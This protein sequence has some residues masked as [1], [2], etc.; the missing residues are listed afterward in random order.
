MPDTPGALILA[1]MIT[2]RLEPEDKTLD[3]DKMPTALKLL[4]TLGL[5]STDAL[6]IR[7]DELLTPDRRLRPGDAVTVRKV[8]SRG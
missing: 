7:G 8:V 6:V 1:P 5:R 3:Y 4:N 2:V